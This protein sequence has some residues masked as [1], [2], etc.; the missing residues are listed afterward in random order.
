MQYSKVECPIYDGYWE[1]YAD[2]KDFLER[3]HQFEL[4]A[5]N[6]P[7]RNP[8]QAQRRNWPG[9]IIV[10]DEERKEFLVPRI[11]FLALQQVNYVD[12]VKRVLQANPRRHISRFTM[13][14]L[15]VV[16]VTK[17]YHFEDTVDKELKIGEVRSGCTR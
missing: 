13:R 3:E 15:W 14:E 16:I 7:R 10:E 9:Y 12:F 6:K 8:T 4:C 17:T 2:E 5:F 1:K 11:S